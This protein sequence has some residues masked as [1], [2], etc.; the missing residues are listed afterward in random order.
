MNNTFQLNKVYTNTAFCN[1][2]AERVKQL[3][4]F[5]TELYKDHPQDC[6]WPLS[7][8]EY[9]KY[10]DEWYPKI[11]NYIVPIKR[12]RCFVICKTVYDF[13]EK[14]KIRL[15]ENG[16]EY[17]VIEGT[18]IYAT[19]LDSRDMVTMNITHTRIERERG[20]HRQYIDRLS[21]LE[22]YGYVYL[23]NTTKVESISELKKAYN[24]HD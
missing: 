18:K 23:D 10:I 9:G 11:L 16:V 8:E 24:R 12:T 2:R 5:H 13:T 15:D 4:G 19:D 6:P 22:E 20:N 7:R 14:K 21:H 17:V 1:V 3:M